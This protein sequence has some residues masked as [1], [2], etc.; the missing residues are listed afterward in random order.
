MPPLFCFFDGNFREKESG[1]F[2]R[3]PFGR[4]DT[5]RI[6]AKGRI[7][8]EGPPQVEQREQQLGRIKRGWNGHR[9]MNTAKS[10]T[11]SKNTTNFRRLVV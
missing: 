9:L 3:A 6:L 5:S 8:I 7:G 1:R 10:D 2:G 11:I 4:R